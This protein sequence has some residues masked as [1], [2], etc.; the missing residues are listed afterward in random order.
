MQAL[1]ILINSAGGGIAL[2]QSNAV[3]GSSVA[4][5]AAAFPGSNTAGNLLLAF[6]RMSTSTQTVTVTDSAGNTYTDA[7]SQKQTADGSQVHLFY[8]KNITGGA[9]TVTAHFSASN[10]HP[11]LA[12]YE[13]SGLSK[14][15]PLD[16]KASAQG[17]STTPSTGATPLTT[18]ANELLFVGAGLSCTSTVTATG[19]SGY[20]LG[21]QD[22]STSRA[23]TETCLVSATGSYTGTFTLSAAANWSAVIATFSAAGAA[24]QPAIHHHL[25]AGWHSEHCIRC[26]ARSNW[27]KHAVHLVDCDRHATGR[28]IAGG[29]HW[30]DFRHAHRNRHEQFHSESRRS[31]L[32]NRNESTQHCHQLRRRRDCAVAIECGAG[33]FSGFARSRISGPQHGWEFDSRVCADVYFDPD[34]DG[35]R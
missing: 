8:A 33:Q 30:C 20:T 26:N 10:G 31:Q 22:T 28:I 24:S 19:G 21:Q 12:I 6:V 27:W 35:Y 16:Q 29:K 4:T 3:Q 5:L 25:A 13:Y 9:N 23:S 14:T 32:A 1:S 34:R 15:A 2:S 18:S 17:N 11:W 7:V